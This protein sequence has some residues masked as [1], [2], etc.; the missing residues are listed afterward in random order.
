LSFHYDANSDCKILNFDNA[1][2]LAASVFRVEVDMV[3]GIPLETFDTACSTAT[4]DKAEV[5]Y[6]SADNIMKAS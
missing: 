6:L 5:R 1:G 2:T 4:C 3:P